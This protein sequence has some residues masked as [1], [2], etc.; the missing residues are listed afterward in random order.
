M[1][2]DAAAKHLPGERGD[3]WGWLV[4][5]TDEDVAGA[6]AGAMAWG[7][8]WNPLSPEAGDRLD[9]PDAVG[10]DVETALPIEVHGRKDAGGD[11]RNCEYDSQNAS[12]GGVF[13]EN[14]TT[15]N[16]ISTSRT[17]RFSPL[18]TI[19]KSFAVPEST[20]NHNLFRNSR[21]YSKL[22]LLM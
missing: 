6:Y 14:P 19:S 4:V 13:H 15:W 7:E 8:R 12:L 9:P 1:G 17:K 20:K 21:S 5:D 10:W 22:T 3:A 16:N 18:C 11:G 2:P